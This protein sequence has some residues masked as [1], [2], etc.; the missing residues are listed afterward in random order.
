MEK[1]GVV[2]S[3]LPSNKLIRD[4]GIMGKKKEQSPQ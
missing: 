4:G 2:K 3:T 1:D